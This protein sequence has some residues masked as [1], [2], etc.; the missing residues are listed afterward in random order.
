MPVDSCKDKHIDYE[1]SSVFKGSAGGGAFC[2]PPPPPPPWA[3]ANFHLKSQARHDSA[4]TLQ[5]KLWNAEEAIHYFVYFSSKLHLP[6][7]ILE[8]LVALVKFTSEKTWLSI[9]VHTR[10][11]SLH[12]GNFLGQWIIC[13]L[14]TVLGKKSFSK[15]SFQ[16]K[17]ELKKWQKWGRDER[18]QEDY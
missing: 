9:T 5:H 14:N 1:L 18:V 10:R 6:P 15:T 13:I 3:L 16:L 17:T 7:L 4:A 11:K 8:S 12:A 2:P